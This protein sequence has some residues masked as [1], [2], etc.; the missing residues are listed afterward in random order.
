MNGGQLRNDIDRLVA[1]IAPDPGPGMTPLARELA[2]EITSIPVAPQTA[3]RHRPWATVPPLSTRRRPRWTAMPPLNT[4]RRRRWAAVPALAALAAVL[5]FGLGQAPASAALDIEREGDHYVIT[6]KDLMAD[7]QV[8]QSELRARGLDITLRLVPT[9][10]SQAGRMFVINDTDL[11]RSGRPVPEE[12]PI[13]PIDAPG[14]CAWARG[15][16]IGVRVPVDYDKKAEIILGRLAEAGEKYAMPPGI[17]MPGEPL[18]CVDYVNKTVAEIGPMLR[19]RGVEAEFIS[20]GQRSAGP[21]APEGWYVQDGVMSAAG[22]ALMLIAP[23][24]NP[25]H[26]APNASCPVP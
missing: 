19:E 26:P 18:H 10:A 6:V 24:P 12:G 9:S 22:K 4:R 21:S 15:C 14:P 5:T 3:R 23:E 8:Y 11:L 2:A 7:P 13:T 17:A 1:G 25:Q 16:Q 20:H